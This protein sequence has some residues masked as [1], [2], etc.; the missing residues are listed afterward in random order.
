MN[1]IAD[2]LKFM[3]LFARRGRRQY[4]HAQR[5]E[6]LRKVWL[7]HGIPTYVARKLDSGIDTGGWDSI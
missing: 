7:N 6:E 5:L 4:L 2:L 3:I 1:M